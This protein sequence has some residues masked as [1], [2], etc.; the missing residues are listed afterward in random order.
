MAHAMKMTKASCGHMFKH[1]ERAKDKDGNYIKFSNQSIDL[2]RTELNYNLGPKR[3]ISQGEFVRQT[4]SSEVYC[5]NR[6]DVNVCVDWCITAPEDL[7][8]EQLGDFFQK[9]YDFLENRYSICGKSYVVSSYVHLD[10]VTPH[11]H[12]CFIPVVLDLKKDKVRLKVSAKEKIDKKELTK[13]HPELEKY[14]ADNG[15]YCSILNEATKEGN[16]SIE[17]L[18]RQS[19]TE[20]LQQVAT[21]SHRM[22]TEA[23]KEVK[24]MKSTLET[25][26]AEYEA[27]KAY[28][29]E[30]DNLSQVTEM[31]PWFA[32][33][34]T[35]GIINK[36]SYVTVPVDAWEAMH[37]SRDEKNYLKAAYV[38]LDEKIKEFEKSVDYRNLEDLKKQV[39]DLKTENRELKKSQQ[40]LQK[41]IRKLEKIQKHIPAEVMEQA[42]VMAKL[43]KNQNRSQKSR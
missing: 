14:L 43:Q 3:D 38:K 19:A 15:I 35:K 24:A 13:F 30:M 41:D 36:Q 11:M 40:S 2:S 31:Y 7:P 29:E 16:R 34:S 32:E 37:V 26:K 28:I 21:E 22:L 42:Q 4:C 23:K 33:K 27:K 9:T 25:L 6:K 39:A 8:R 17:E 12:F 20:R 10:E 1:Y 5:M 18:K